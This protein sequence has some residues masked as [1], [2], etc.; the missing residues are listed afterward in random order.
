MG[1]AIGFNRP[2]QLHS[3]FIELERLKLDGFDRGF[4]VAHEVAEFFTL[5]PL[6]SLAPWP[7]AE[8]H[9]PA[10]LLGGTLSRRATMGI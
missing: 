4:G 2:E 8:K 1:P 5:Q 9:L 3:H 6:K 10:P 7:A